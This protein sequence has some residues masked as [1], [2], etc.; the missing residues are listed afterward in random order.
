MCNIQHIIIIG[1]KKLNILIGSG[2]SIYIYIFEL[3]RIP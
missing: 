1:I 2:K 3:S